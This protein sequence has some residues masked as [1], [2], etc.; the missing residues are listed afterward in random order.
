MSLFITRLFIIFTLTLLAV[1]CTTYKPRPI[2][3]EEGHKG[4]EMGISYFTLFK[5]SAPSGF[6]MYTYI[7]MGRDVNVSGDIA[8]QQRLNRLLELVLS[9]ST[10]ESITET[11]KSNHNLFIYPSIRKDFKKDANR[12]AQYSFQ[13]S[14][15]TRFRVMD[16]LENDNS[17]IKLGISDKQKPNITNA[18]NNLRT[19]DGPFLVSFN[20]PFSAENVTNINRML[21]GDLSGYP[22]EA[23]ST[24]IEE[25][26]QVVSKEEIG[27]VVFDSWGGR[28]LN[29]IDKIGN[30]VI[31]VSSDFLL[32]KGVVADAHLFD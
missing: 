20:A 19:H 29:L 22:P 32:I 9:H 26:Q 27:I 10:A 5:E 12:V 13:K 24:V 21:I 8:T 30:A 1:S 18:I 25:Y 11:Q 16:L 2:E 3:T 28:I 14:N 6:G 23:I 15:E 4:D 7:L 31:D 17:L